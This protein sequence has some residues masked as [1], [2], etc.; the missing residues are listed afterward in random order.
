MRRQTTEQGITVAT[1]TV[2]EAAPR[3]GV[4][5]NTFYKA[6]SDGQIPHIRVGRKILVLRGPFED[7]LAGRRATGEVG[8]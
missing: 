5:V 4:C 3:M 7:M 1:M 6:V 8:R 2:S